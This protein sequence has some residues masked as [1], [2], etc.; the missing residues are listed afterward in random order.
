MYATIVLCELHSGAADLAHGPAW[1]TL[2]AALAALPGF[3]AFV[4][5]EM[6]A[7]AGTVAALCLVEEHAGLAE[8]E[9]VIAQWQREQVAAGES[10]V[11]RLGKG[12]V[13]AQQGL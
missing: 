3:V 13:I 1:R 5:L 8:A 9:R 12:E 2:T 7:G 10:G 11:R 4:A 6:D